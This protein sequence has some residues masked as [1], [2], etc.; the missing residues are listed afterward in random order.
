MGVIINGINYNV[1]TASITRTLRKEYKY[2]VKTEDGREHSEIR[3]IYA[4]YTL[5]LGNL[6]ASAYDGLMAALLAHPG[7]VT[8][9]LPDSSSGEKTFTGR[10][11]DITDS[12]IAENDDTTYWDNLT[13]SFIGTTPLGVVQ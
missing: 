7:E 5:S 10:F 12:V 13:L 3:A 6:D 11:E 1:G 2:Q 4:D 8:V 9:T